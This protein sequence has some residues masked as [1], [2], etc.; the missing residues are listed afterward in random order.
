MALITGAQPNR[1]NPTITTS[2]LIT[3]IIGIVGIGALLGVGWVRESRQRQA[4]R[5]LR[6]IASECG[7]RIDELRILNE[8]TASRELGAIELD[9]QAQAKF[10]L[11]IL[12][13]VDAD[14]IKRLEN[15]RKRVRSSDL[16]SRFQ[17]D[18]PAVWLV[19]RA[20]RRIPFRFTLLDRKTSSAPMNR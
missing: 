13:T 15:F 6:G 9:T 12:C 19:E 8:E 10:G 17:Y 5:E 4:I 11:Y 7:V 1:R 16:L 14:E 2:L 20:D 18:C 3:L